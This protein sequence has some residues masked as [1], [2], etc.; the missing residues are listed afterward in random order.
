MA[1]NVGIT[2]QS[3]IDLSCALVS[4]FSRKFVCGKRVNMDGCSQDT[5]LLTFP[6]SNGRFMSRVVNITMNPHN[7]T[8]T[9]TT[10]THT[11]GAVRGTERGG[12]ERGVRGGETLSQ[13]TS[14]Q[15]PLREFHAE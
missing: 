4:Y 6:Y 1:S 3:L 7:H 15:T 10:H 14:F 11:Y 5:H 12:A 13:S 9:T 2:L 8:R